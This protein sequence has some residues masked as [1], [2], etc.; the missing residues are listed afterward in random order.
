M[1]PA[2]LTVYASND[3]P[4]R[5]DILFAS[6]PTVKGVTASAYYSDALLAYGVPADRILKVQSAGVRLVSV[7]VNETSGTFVD[8]LAWGRGGSPF[9]ATRMI[10]GLTRDPW[11][12]I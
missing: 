6:T 3:N 10:S 7:G 8:A 9:S 1:A 4:A 12:S 11:R 5:A 2:N